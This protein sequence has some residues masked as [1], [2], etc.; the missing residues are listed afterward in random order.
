M[1]KYAVSVIVPVYNVEKYIKEC[2]ES[3]VNQ[4]L[5]NIEIIV[6]NDGSPDNSQSIIDEYTKKYPDKIKSYVKKNGGLSDAR[7]YGIK[8]ANGEYIAFVDSDDFVDVT[9]FEKMYSEALEK[10]SEI[11]VCKFIKFTEKQAFL[12]S[13]KFPKFGTYNVITDPSLLIIAKSYAC[14]KIFKKELFLKSK[15]LFPKGQNFEDSAIV[16]NL[17]L[18]AKN[19]TFIDEGLYYYRRH[20]EESITNDFSEKTFDI[21]K[22]CDSI[23]NFYK[24]N[25]VYD[26]LYEYVKE[27]CLLHIIRR[28]IVSSSSAKIDLRNEFIDKSFQYLNDKFPGWYNSKIV[29]NMYK[30]RGKLFVKFIKYKKF[31]KIYENKIY[32][33]RKTKLFKLLKKMLKIPKRIIN[34]ILRILKLKKKVQKSNQYLIPNYIDEVKNVQKYN[35]DI[36]K[37]VDKLCKKNKLTYFLSEGSLLGAVRHNGFIPWDDD[38]DIMMPREDYEKFIDIALKE[39]K[40]EYVLQCNKNIDNYWVASIKVRMTKKTKYI[41]KELAGITD[42]IGPYIDIFPLDYLPK[43]SS[44]IQKYYMNKVKNLK[45]ILWYKFSNKKLGELKGIKKKFLIICGRLSSYKTIHKKLYN[46]MTHFN[47]KKHNFVINYGSY[48]DYKKQIFPYKYYEKAKDIPFEDTKLPV[49][50]EAEKILSKI[51]GN[52]NML[53]NINNRYPKHTFFKT[54][55]DY[56][57]RKKILLIV[58]KDNWAFYNIATNIMKNLSKFYDIKIVSMLSENISLQKLFKTY[59]NYDCYHFFWRKLLF[60]IK[61]LDE[62]FINKYIK[63]KVITTSVY[64]HL[65]LDEPMANM[66]LIEEYIK[67]YTVSSNKLFEIYSKISSI[68]KPKVTI[69]DGVDLKKFYPKNLNRF[70]IK[71]RPLIVGWVGNSEW[72]KSQNDL[73]GVNT[74]LKPAI[75]ELKEEGY[76]IEEL[77][78]DRVNGFIPHDEMIDYYSKIDVCVCTSKT[79]GT[80]NPVLEAMACGDAIVSTDVGIVPNVLGKKQQDFILKERSKECLKKTLIKLIKDRDLIK[81]LSQENINSIKAWDWTLKCEEFKQFFDSVI[82]EEN[83]N[84]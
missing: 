60:P 58:D 16:Y 26:K 64:D 61:K 17:L 78:A 69:T 22:S 50:I 81:S 36:L 4:T 59:K 62:Q 68:K 10:K 43:E 56:F 25:K 47:N 79:E 66:D 21:F 83:K 38:I 48:Y 82:N 9:M 57:K 23:I 53:P 74:I 52:Y 24:K 54:D 31:Y 55:V 6:V 72:V 51:Y 32:K 14:N 41:Q 75:K 45:L 49:P 37:A 80:P 13:E 11:V 3:L 27:I 46:S 39:L 12:S 19:V 29:K 35:L 42:N 5:K 30:S 65:Y 67:E 73:K 2:L 15:I 18:I 63:N 40:N 44:F 33:Y 28:L 1:K 84:D 71:D 77:F 8:K 7:N 76:N 70:N 34:K 20:R